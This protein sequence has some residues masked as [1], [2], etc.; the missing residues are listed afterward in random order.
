MIH[1]RSCVALL[2]A[3]IGGCGGGSDGGN[4]DPSAVSPSPSPPVETPAPAAPTPLPPPPDA[5]PPAQPKRS[6]RGDVL[7]AALSLPR[8]DEPDLARAIASRRAGYP[9]TATSVVQRTDRDDPQATAG[10][11]L[12][13]SSGYMNRSPFIE[14]RYDLATA[15]IIGA[16]SMAGAGGAT[17]FAFGEEMEGDTGEASERLAKPGGLVVSAGQSYEVDQA[18]GQWVAPAGPA[19]WNASLQI[20]SDHADTLFRVCWKLKFPGRHRTSCGVFDSERGDLIGVHVVDDSLAF[21]P[22]VWRTGSL[23]PAPAGASGTVSGEV[24]IKALSRPRYSDPVAGAAAGRLTEGTISSATFVE[25]QVERDDPQ[26]P[27]GRYMF[28]SGGYMNLDRLISPRYDLQLASLAGRWQ[29]TGSGPQAT[30]TLFEH[31]DGDDGQESRGLP[32][33]DNL[34][35]SAAQSYELGGTLAQ[36]TTSEAPYP[37]EVS[38]EIYPD[39]A[40]PDWFRL[41]WQM[42]YYPRVFRLSCGLFDRQ[43]GEFMGVHVVD[44]TDP[45]APLIWRSDGAGQPM[46]E[47]QTARPAAEGPAAGS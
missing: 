31:V 1:R 8:Y 36:W 7:I 4:D 16:W 41:C 40:Q 28:S 13:N 39:E 47:P 27:V 12:F 15:R 3:I 37:W 38:L 11:Y 2:L 46:P 24:L 5:P 17:T 44:A 35:V 18:L 34:V 9:S 10:R 20:Q 25:Q 22:L 19:A 43:G 33:A 21:G 23:P 32:R 30:F 26:T 29:M 6:I 14:S 45:P 42:T